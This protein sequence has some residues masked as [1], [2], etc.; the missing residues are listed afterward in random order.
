MTAGEDFLLFTKNLDVPILDIGLAG[1]H[2]DY[3]DFIKPD[4][5][6]HRV[7]KG[8][9]RHSRPF[10]VIKATGKLDT[11]DEIPLFQT[12]FQRY[13]D[14]SYLWMGCGNYGKQLFDTCGGMKK[15]HFD[16]LTKLINGETISA[17]EFTRPDNLKM[18]EIKLSEIL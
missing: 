15:H 8:I 12:F 1:G 14:I 11:G 17:K 6:T 4:E 13:T 3:I 16:A 5:I 10:L 18:S 2:T 9:D 7:M